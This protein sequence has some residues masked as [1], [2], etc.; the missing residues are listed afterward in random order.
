VQDVDPEFDHDDKVQRWRR[1]EL[2][3]MFPAMSVS[4][5]EALAAS[6]NRE[7][8]DRAALLRRGDCSAELAVRILL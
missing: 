2:L 4:D 3:R 1:D 7:L 8:L 6:D 5:A